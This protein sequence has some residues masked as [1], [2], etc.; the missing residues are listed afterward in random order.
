MHPAVCDI[1]TSICSFSMGFFVM[2]AP[3]A[4]FL[5]NS[6]DASANFTP[7]VSKPAPAAAFVRLFTVPAHS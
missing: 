5:P 6:F 4:N 7:K 3:L 1:R 2:L